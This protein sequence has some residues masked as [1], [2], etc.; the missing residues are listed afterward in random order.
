MYQYIYI[1]SVVVYNCVFSRTSAYYF[2]GAPKPSISPVT[3][4]YV[5][6]SIWKPDKV[7]E[8]PVSSTSWA[9]SVSK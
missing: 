4:L 1:I 8:Q 9:I 7:T 3:G 2:V 6:K 5:I